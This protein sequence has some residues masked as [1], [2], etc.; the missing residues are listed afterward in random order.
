MKIGM[1]DVKKFKIGLLKFDHDA[2]YFSG[3]NF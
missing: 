2:I 3:N 1:I